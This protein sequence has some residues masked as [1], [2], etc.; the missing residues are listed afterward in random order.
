MEIP[1]TYMRG[2]TSKACFF[3]Q[4]DLPR[5]PVLRDRFI[6]AAYG[7]PDPLGRQLDGIGGGVSST[8]KVAVID[9]NDSGEVLYD[10]GQVDITRAVV[11]R[12]GLCGNIASAVGPY[13]IDAGLVPATGSVTV[14]PIRDV[15]SGL[16]FRAHVPTTAGKYDDTGH[17]R[18]AGVPRPGSRIELELLEPGGS[19]TG[20]LLPTGRCQDRILLSNGSKVTVSIVDS[21]GTVAF[22]SDDEFHDPWRP[23]AEL[24]EDKAFLAHVEDIRSSAVVALGLAPDRATATRDWLAQVSV[25][26]VARS[27]SYPADS[28]EEIEPPAGIPSVRTV[29]SSAGVMHRAYPVT[30]AFCTATASALPGTVVAELADASTRSDV[31]TVICGPAGLVEAR[32]EVSWHGDTPHV[33]SVRCVRTARRIMRGWL[34]CPDGYL[35]DD[36][37]SQSQVL[38]GG[39]DRE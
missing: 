5:D 28:G 25:A 13:A 19:V 32:A 17:T 34:Y 23:V 21:A 27:G 4:Q 12:G 30:G 3:R 39:S 37:S 18:I 1:T 14:V 10:F 2:G 24:N 33:A 6:L 15:N 8:S 11:D 26:I 31:A 29:I 9:C 22:V 35:A 36:S 20:T 16:L 38:Q 7:S